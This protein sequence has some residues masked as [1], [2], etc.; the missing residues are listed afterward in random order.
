[1]E[2]IG[3]EQK[4][5]DELLAFSKRIWPEKSEEYLKYRLFQIPE[6]PDDIKKNLLVLNDEGKIVGCILYFPTRAKILGVEEK[7]YWGHDMVVEEEYRGAAGLML[8]IEMNEN[9]TAF[10]FG[11]TEINYKIQKELGTKFIGA[12]RHYVIFNIL[13]FKLPL[14]RWKLLKT[15]KKENFRF[16]EK[17][18]AGM[19]TFRKIYS[20]SDMKIP[21]DGYWTSGAYDIEFIRDEHFFKNRFFENFISYQVYKLENHGDKD[22]CYFVLRP[23]E[24]GG[25][26][27]LSIVDFRFNPGKPEQFM[28]L[29][30]AASTL[31]RMNGIPLTTCRTSYNFRRLNLCPLIFGRNALEHIVTCYP[32]NANSKLMVTNADADLDFLNIR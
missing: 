10:G 17:I 19:S 25:Y 27:V 30:K 23:L 32:A 13:S 9:R 31:A 21:G 1:M 3:F 8:I 5:Y 24:E 2:V 29:V 12:A 28:F 11:T 7:V 22:E 20:V 18:S 6:D 16:P 26:P 4:Y 14:Y 15:G